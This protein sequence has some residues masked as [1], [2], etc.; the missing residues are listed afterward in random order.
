MPSYLDA[1]TREQL[2]HMN[3]PIDRFLT[4]YKNWGIGQG[5]KQRTVLFFPGGLGS[6]LDA[7]PSAVRSQR[8][9]RLCL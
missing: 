4:D 3:G 8:G 6:E 2:K 1:L 7:G 9:H 5:G